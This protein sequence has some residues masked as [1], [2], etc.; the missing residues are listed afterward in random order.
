MRKAKVI[1]ALDVVCRTHTLMHK[2]ARSLIERGKVKINGAYVLDPNQMIE[3]R[4]SISVKIG[5][6]ENTYYV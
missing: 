3:N 4:R 1:S 5:A 6:A 2:Y